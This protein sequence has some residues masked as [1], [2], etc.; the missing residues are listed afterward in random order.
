[1]NQVIDALL[2]KYYLVWVCV[3][4]SQRH[5]DW[6]SKLFLLRHQL[7]NMVYTHQIET[8]GTL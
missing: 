8:Y 7:L 5:N 3:T 1:M 6:E 2:G 4:T